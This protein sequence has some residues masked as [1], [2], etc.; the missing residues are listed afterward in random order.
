VFCEL[1]TVVLAT[2]LVEA[3]CRKSSKHQTFDGETDARG[4][5]CIQLLTTACIGR[6]KSTGSD[7]ERFVE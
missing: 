7:A 6:P 1:R 3:A 5:V 2:L 4:N